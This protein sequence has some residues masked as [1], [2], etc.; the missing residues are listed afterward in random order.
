MP[1]IN[2]LEREKIRQA[3]ENLPRR[4]KIAVVSLAFLAIAVIVFSAL[5]FHTKLNAPFA[6]G[7][8]AD[9]NSA[10]ST[11]SKLIDSDDD[12]L[13]DYDEIN[14]Y[15]TSPYLEDS[16]SDGIS[17]YEEV[18]AGTNPNCPTGKVCN[19]SETTISA[20]SSTVDNVAEGL[21]IDS[22][23]TV[24]DTGAVST[25]G[26]VTP[27]ILR[28]IL[29]QSG[30]LTA[31]ELEKISDEEIMANYRKAVADQGTSEQITPSTGTSTSIQ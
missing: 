14:N 7:N 1:V 5:Q 25:T 20:A 24:A 18:A 3:E 28:Q 22:G 27:A 10:T 17:D 26:E 9:N 4:Q 21:T 6:T 31:A 12:K 15:Q 29:L 11:D 16:D 13:S 23:A 8:L 2:P 30:T 19:S